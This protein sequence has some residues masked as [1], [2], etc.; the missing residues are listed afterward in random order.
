MPFVILFHLTCQGPTE[1]V[2]V[3]SEV[4]PWKNSTLL[5]A[6]STSEAA[7]TMP[8]EA[9]ALSWVLPLGKRIDTR[10]RALGTWGDVEVAA[11]IVEVVETAGVSSP[12][13]VCNCCWMTKTFARIACS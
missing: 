9:G 8:V 12:A 3:P 2:A 7:A 1:P 13:R 4:L 11:G 10:G 5:M 6:P